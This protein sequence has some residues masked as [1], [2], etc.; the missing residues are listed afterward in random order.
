[1]SEEILKAL[2]QL[3]AIISKQ[4]EGTTENQREYV[5]SFL[6]SQLNKEKVN[7]YL[8]YYDEQSGSNE[9]E[10]ADGSQIRSGKLT[11]MKDSVR[12]LSICRKIN[13]TL[14]QKQKVIVLVRIFELLKAEQL[15][16]EQRMG[17]IETIATVFNIIAEELDLISRFSR[18]DTFEEMLSED[19][20]VIENKT[21]DHPEGAGKPKFLFT[22]GLDD[23]IYILRI[24]SVD[25]YFVKYKGYN[26][27]TLN[28]MSF[29]LNNIYLFPQGSTIR[30]PQGT[31]YY[32]D[33]I[34]RFLKDENV[35]HISFRVDKVSYTFPNG[36]PALH[37]IQ[38]EE[39]F[40]LIGIMG[41]SGSGK[42][43][44]LNILSG[45]EK[46]TIGSVTI[47]GTDVH[48][49]PEK[50]KGM[51]GYIAQDDFLFEDLTVFE[52]L[53]YNARLCFRDLSDEE[54]REKVK[55]TLNDLGLYEIRDIKVGSPL[56]KKISGGQRKRLNIALE[57]IREPSVLFVD[58][59]TSGLSSKD[60]E[61]VMDLL[62]ELSLNMKLIFVVIH[63]PSSDIFKM[64]DKLFML[65]TGGYPIYYGNP[66]QALIYFKTASNQINADVGE[67]NSCG[68]VNPE[69]LFNIIE[70]KEVD[71]FGR[72]THNRIKTPLEWNESFRSGFKAPEVSRISEPLS[73]VL[74]IPSW[75]R[76][77]GIFITRDVLSKIGNLQYMVINLLEAPLL[78]VILTVIIRYASGEDGS[79][80]F[81]DNDNIAPYIFMSIVIALFVGLSVSAEEIF[82][83]R[84]ILKRESFLNLSRSSYLF[85]KIV[86]LFVLSAVQTVTFVLLGNSILG[87]HGMF[88]SYWIVLFSVSFYSNILGLNISSA[89]NSAVAIYILI[90]LLVIPQMALGGA[91]FSF[92]KLNKAI[93]GG[94]TKTPLIA[95]MMASRWA[96]EAIAVSQFRDNPYEKYFYEMDKIE[97]MS[98]Y[99]QSRLIPELEN[100]VRESEDLLKNNKGEGCS[101]LSGNLA[102]L[103][104]E[105]AMESRQFPDLPAVNPVAL[106]EENFNSEV[107][108]LVY[109]YLDDLNAKY[110]Q[111]FNIINR[112]K[113]EQVRA[114]QEALGKD[115]YV[116]LYRDNYNDFL[117]SLLKK[118]NIPTRIIR[119]GD[120]FTQVMDPVFLDPENKGGISFRVG[121][122]SPVKYFFGIRMDTLWFNIMVI[123]AFSLL[124]YI[125]LYYDL[126]GRLLRKFE[127]R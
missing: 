97:S 17:I 4:D 89:F 87:I 99:K 40:G 55:T 85:S 13:K 71:D 10:N 96:Y 9:S 117:A 124:F 107:A 22:S 37:D 63:Q 26:E 46:P 5:K 74:R 30:L 35:K 59:P 76:Q 43:T 52:N 28:G 112:K 92:D 31:I 126:L 65:D 88:L 33:V 95:D 2:M 48:K 11:S 58:E 72:F 66:I 53:Y 51:I 80:I 78:A 114:M 24:K 61:N 75:F 25:M 32:S 12:T 82:R 81:K 113:S 111:V 119:E 86:I 34:S 79:Y 109:T 3:F 115:G 29:N 14:S 110:V 6:S 56:N 93:G 49:Q 83:D 21:E 42:T 1:M 16:T 122:Y 62:K 98:S 38:I 19:I 68:N 125:T 70:A 84:K 127:K 102:L 18:F 105:L 91:M 73:A 20:L 116:K 120:R 8:Q 67:C 41:A 103:R 57:L 106:T 50:A 90:P 94:Y 69:L 36:T 100:I 101:E 15:Y 23:R 60:S 64:F 121:F 39:E 77:L 108:G 118:T 54:I 27:I 104:N 7:E 44:L 123:W 47:N 45:I